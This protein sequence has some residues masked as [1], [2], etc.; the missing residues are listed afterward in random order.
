[1]PGLPFF[2]QTLGGGLGGNMQF[3]IGTN[4]Q[5]TYGRAF[6]INVGGPKVELKGGTPQEDAVSYGICA[7]IGTIILIYVVAYG[8]LDDDQARAD[9]TIALQICLDVQFGILMWLE[10]IKQQTGPDY[11]PQEA[12]RKALFKHEH[13]QWSPPQPM[14]HAPTIDAAGNVHLVVDP[15]TTPTPEGWEVIGAGAAVLGAMV[16][17]L[18]VAAENERSTDDDKAT[19]NTK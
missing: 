14:V 8:L 7:I 1:M 17:P 18:V 13:V 4:A 2:A 11:Q 15:D 6:E 9:L 3:T 12:I 16:A 10:T 5:V 19:R